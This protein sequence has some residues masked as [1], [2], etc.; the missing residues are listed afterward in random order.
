LACHGIC[1]AK[2]VGKFFPANS[3][4]KRGAYEAG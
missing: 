4:K 2:E 3:Q 1:V